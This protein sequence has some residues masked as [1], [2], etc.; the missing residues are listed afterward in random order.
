MILNYFQS[1][2]I[3]PFI[4]ICS[5][6]GL[7]GQT[8]SSFVVD[9]VKNIIPVFTTTVDLLDNELQSQDIS[10][11]LQSSRDVYVNQAGFNF[12]AAR[13]RL[14]GY[15][16]ENTRLF[17]NGIPVNDPENGWTIWSYWGGL[18]DVT[19]YPETSFGITN[20]AANFGSI[21]AY[22]YISA[23]PS[24]KRTGSRVSYASTNRSYRNRAMYTYNSGLNNKGWG[25]LISG[26]SRWSDEGYVPGSFYSS[27][28]YLLSVEKKFNENHSLNFMAFGAPT[29]QGRQGI[30]VQETYDLTGDPF[31]NPYWGYQ[32]QSDGSL[33]KRNART[34]DN[35]K[36]YM[37]LG[38]YWKVSEKLNIQSNFYAILGKTSNTN[39]NW[40]DANDPRPD[41]YKYLPSYFINDQGTLSG[42]Q[43][44]ENQEQYDNISQ[45]W[46]Q[47]NPD[48]TQLNWDLMYNANYNNLYT[49]N[50]I[51]N[52]DSSYTGRRSKYIVEEYRLD[53]RHY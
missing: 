50:N 48:Y 52:I 44:I 53:P 15:S 1:R 23:L 8:D 13:Y 45:Q 3:F 17:M 39:L 30:A 47:N 40:V 46:Q 42:N 32:T 41:Y 33:K 21:G 19:R 37:T 9:T 6:T 25:F 28:S 34:R 26:S 2:F 14:R 35:H 27:G 43:I 49:Q 7:K 5:F 16:S 24:V 22:S 11:L 4:L 20:S 10:G 29:V 12:S 36:P 51:G 18:N 31:Y 38:H